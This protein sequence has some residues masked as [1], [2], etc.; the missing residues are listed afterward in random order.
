M[1]IRP[2]VLE[3]TAPAAAPPSPVAPTT[4]PDLPTA[5]LFGITLHALT[6]AAAVQHVSKWLRGSDMSCRYIVT[7]NVDHLVMLEQDHELGAAYADASLTVADGLPLV[8]CSRILG[9]RLPERVAGSDLVPGLFATADAS[10]PLRVF[11]LGAAPGVAA[12][13]AQHITAQFPAVDVVDTYS[14]PLGFETDAIENAYIVERVAAARP[15]LLVIGLGAPKQEK[16]V[17]AHRDVLAAKVAICAGAT[18]D[19]LAG[20]R[21]RA[22]RWLQK[23][24][25]EWCYRMLSEPRRLVRRY[26]VDALRFPGI[27][28]RARRQRQT[29]R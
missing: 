18:I 25:L 19:F 21:R 20:H 5:T 24:G 9:A 17:R 22:P 10:H 7:P 23:L 8:V 26:A 6:I 15:D 1:T 2:A 11:L 14:P 27:V 4:E 16:W 28:W 29:H 3:R 12:R 13:A